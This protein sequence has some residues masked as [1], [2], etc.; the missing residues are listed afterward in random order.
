LPY[1]IAKAQADYGT[2][3][4]SGNDDYAEGLYVDYRHFDNAAIAPRYEFGFGLSYTT[5]AYSALTI[6]ALSTTA[7][8]TTLIPGGQAGLFDIVATV[9]CKISNCASQSTKTAARIH[10]DDSLGWSQR[11]CYV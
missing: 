11:H 1:T 7:G 10:E 3:I 8:S 9:T 6:S 5:F 4:A 2:A